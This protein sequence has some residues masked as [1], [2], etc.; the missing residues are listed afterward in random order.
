[1]LTTIDQSA[2]TLAD[3]TA[4]VLM[5]PELKAETQAAVIVELCSLLER[6]GRLHDRAAFVDA[7]MARELMSSTAISPNWALPH[8]RLKELPQ[9]S[10]ALA[11]SR[12]PLAWRGETR[13]PVRTVFLFAAPESEAKAYLNLISAVAK[14]SKSPALVEQL[15]LA[16][17]AETMFSVLQTV[18][19]RH[20]RPLPGNLLPSGLSGR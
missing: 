18:C 5:V 6:H 11:R 16:H 15:A 12:Q 13:F 19:L 2:K 10:F 8:A 4:P 3:Y 20:S 7:V 9:L 14:L 17:D 1:M